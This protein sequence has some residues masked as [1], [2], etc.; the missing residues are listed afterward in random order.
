MTKDRFQQTMSTVAETIWGKDGG[1]T[2]KAQGAYLISEAGTEYLKK[3]GEGLKV[4][5]AAL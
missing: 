1:T 5:V 2:W 4:Y 3:L